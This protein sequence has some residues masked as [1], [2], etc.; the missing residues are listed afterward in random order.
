MPLTE[1]LFGDAASSCFTELG[2]TIK[3][4]SEIDAAGERSPPRPAD[5][6]G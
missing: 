6:F 3:R 5:H 4:G 2:A 1:Q